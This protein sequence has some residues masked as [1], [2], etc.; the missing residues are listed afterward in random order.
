MEAPV[1]ES[2]KIRMLRSVLGSRFRPKAELPIYDDI[3]TAKYLIDWFSELDKYFDYE[4][5]D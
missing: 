1:L 4:D 5:I 3:L 2:T